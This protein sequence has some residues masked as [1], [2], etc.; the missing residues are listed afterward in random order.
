MRGFAFIAKNYLKYFFILFFALEF[1]FIGAD[2]IKY[3]DDLPDSAN[4]VILFFFYDALYALNYTLP[5]SMILGSI[6]FYINFLKSSQLSALMALG[7][8]KLKILFPILCISF[9]MTLGYIGLNATP[10]VYAQ[11]KAEAIIDK[12]ALQN[13]QEDIFVKYNQSYVYFQKVYPLLNRAENIKVFELGSDRKLS[14]LIYAPNAYFEGRY[15]VLNNANVSE[16]NEEFI[17]GQDALKRKKVDKLKIL[18]DFRPKVL[19]TFS[20]DKPTVSI[21][22]AIVSAKILINQKID[23]EKVRAILYS[24]ILIP[25]FVPLSIIIITFFIPPLARYSNLAMLSFELVV[26]ALVLWGIFFSIAKLSIAGIIYP[27]FGIL[28]PLGLLFLG[29]FYCLIRMNRR[30]G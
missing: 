2:S 6:I 18:K 3:I 26:F 22:D 11:E 13:A 17:P 24:F 21:V 1:F 9:M 25:L 14:S 30:F 20:K 23:F 5:L 28:I 15:W 27:E 8:S 10:F 12:N 4:L 7:Y 19:D 29:S 16:I